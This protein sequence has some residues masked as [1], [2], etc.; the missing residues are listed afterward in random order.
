[1][2]KDAESTPD[3]ASYYKRSATNLLN[4][5]SLFVDDL[6]W[7]INSF[8]NHVYNIV[9]SFKTSSFTFNYFDNNK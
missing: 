8:V 5:Y 3:A 2:C 7:D 6:C 9:N 1:M 4:Q